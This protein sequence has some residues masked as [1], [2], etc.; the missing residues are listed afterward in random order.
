MSKRL[1]KCARC[2]TVG[3]PERIKQH[4]CILPQCAHSSVSRYVHFS[5]QYQETIHRYR[6]DSC[7]RTVKIQHEPEHEH[8][9]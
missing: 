9:R 4:D 2:G 3:V 6:C 5:E 8:G 7:E 1:K